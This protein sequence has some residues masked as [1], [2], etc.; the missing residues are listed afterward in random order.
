MPPKPKKRDEPHYDLENVA[1]ITECT[2]LIPS[3]LKDEEEA[4]AYGDLYSIHKQIPSD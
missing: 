4:D 3:A 1:S 2:G